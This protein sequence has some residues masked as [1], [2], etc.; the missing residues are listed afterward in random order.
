MDSMLVRVLSILVVLSQLFR[1][2]EPLLAQRNPD[3]VILRSVSEVHLT[4]GS[5]PEIGD[6]KPYRL[7]VVA[8]F[9]NAFGDVLICKKRGTEVWSFPQGGLEMGEERYEQALYREVLEELGNNEFEIVRKSEKLISYDYH[10]LARTTFKGQRQKWFLCS[11]K[12]G[13][14]PALEQAPDDVFDSYSWVSPKHAI[15]R[16]DDFKRANYVRGLSE[17]GLVIVAGGEA[18]NAPE[19][20]QGDEK[21]YRM[22][23]VAVFVNDSG[24][25]LTCKTERSNEWV[26]PQGGVEEGETFEQTLYREVLEEI[27][28]NEFDIIRKA[29]SLMSY[30]FR[31]SRRFDFRGQMQQWYLCRFKPG[32]GPDLD[33]ALDAEFSTFSWVSPKKAVGGAV[34]IKKSRYAEGLSELGL[35]VSQ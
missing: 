33:K 30:E 15:K 24:E 34:Y 4:R 19:C 9:V 35:E 12:K 2:C 25:V 32:M 20:E 21:P 5:S 11:Y 3:G 8:V 29:D 17:L 23:V 10:P 27:G 26:F 1:V 14:E 28:N 7:G 16:A 31:P 18:L 22:G 13:I 6:K